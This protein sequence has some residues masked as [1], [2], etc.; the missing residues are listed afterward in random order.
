M[1]NCS[2]EEA[3]VAWMMDETSWSR[4]SETHSNMS[5]TM[6]LCLSSLLSDNRDVS[7]ASAA[8]AANFTKFKVPSYKVNTNESFFLNNSF[9]L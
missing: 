3:G 1:V 8:L 6:T 2:S 7:S 4:E 9:I 5:V